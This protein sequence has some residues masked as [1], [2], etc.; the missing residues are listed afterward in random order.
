M[1]TAY[2]PFSV[3]TI[4]SFA[5]SFKKRS[6][7]RRISIPAPS[8][9]ASSPPAAPRWARFFKTSTP[10]SMIAWDGV[11]SRFA[12]NPTPQASCSYLGWYNPL[13]IPRTVAVSREHLIAFRAGADSLQRISEGADEPRAY[14][15]VQPECEDSA[16]GPAV[17]AVLPSAAFAVPI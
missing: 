8:P 6:W 9:V 3:L 12:T 2:F 11:P 13:L 5:H 4:P 17:C 14:R 7:G 15:T 1:P 10:R 16:G